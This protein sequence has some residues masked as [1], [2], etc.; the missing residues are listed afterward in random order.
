MQSADPH[1]A[2]FS[3]TLQAQRGVERG[4]STEDQDSVNGAEWATASA[5]DVVVPCFSLA[6]PGKNLLVDASLRIVSGRRYGVMGSNGCGKS[7]LLHFLAARRL[8]IPNGM[9]YCCV[10]HVE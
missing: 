6:A 8:P 1:L 5:T 10:L 7:T 9:L 3:L 2:S 4:P